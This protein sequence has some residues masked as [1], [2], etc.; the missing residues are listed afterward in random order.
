MDE[1]VKN[2]F[3]K[4]LISKQF[5]TLDE[6]ISITSLTLE[7]PANKQANDQVRPTAR[8]RACHPVLEHVSCMTFVV[9]K[10]CHILT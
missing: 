6:P 2:M 1:K 9:F 3:T 7:A 5:L 8:T 10:R 4:L